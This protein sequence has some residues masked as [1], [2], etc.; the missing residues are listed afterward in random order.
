MTAATW[1]KRTAAAGADDEA[2]AAQERSQW[3]Y[4]WAQFHIFTISG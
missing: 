2:G 1:W 3:S 4:F